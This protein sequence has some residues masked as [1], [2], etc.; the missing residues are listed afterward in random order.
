MKK[1]RTR[2]SRFALGILVLLTGLSS[3]A[4][5]YHQHL[6]IDGPKAASVGATSSETSS[7]GPCLVCR[8][9][10]EQAPALEAPDRP[11]PLLVLSPIAPRPL[12]LQVEAPVRS[13]S[14]PRAPP[15]SSQAV[16]L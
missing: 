13:S 14:C 4:G 2:R 6:E 7:S 10:R 9:A 8:A 15:A 11:E 3:L 1:T 5:A 12:A 16:S